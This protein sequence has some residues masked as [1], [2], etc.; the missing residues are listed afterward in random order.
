MKLV[1]PASNFDLSNAYT[2]DPIWVAGVQIILGN[3]IISIWP[4]SK[5]GIIDITRS[6][7]KLVH[8][9]T[10]RWIGGLG[11]AH[12]NCI[13]KEWRTAR[14]ARYCKKEPISKLVII[15]P[16]ICFDSVAL[17]PQ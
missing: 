15:N 10:S 13:G 4:Y 14:N 5:Y 6:I 3:R 1:L 16:W 2:E 8:V 11:Y 17:Q 12:I 9:P 7:R